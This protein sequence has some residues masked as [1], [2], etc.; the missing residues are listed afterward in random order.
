MSQTPPPK[1]TFNRSSPLFRHRQLSP[2]ASVR[3]SPLCL[4]AMTFGTQQSSRYGDCSRSTAFAILDHFYSSGGNF[5]D[6][7]NAYQFGQSEQWLGEWMSSRQNRDEMVV[8]TKY[9]TNYMARRDD[10]VQSNFSGNGAKSLKVSLEA[11]LA[12]LKTTYVDLL[13]VHWWDAATGIAEM[14][15][16]LNDVVVAGKVLYLGVSDTPAWVVSAAN[17]YARANGL[18]PFVVYQGMWSAALRDFER[19]IV[20]MAQQQGMGLC[21]YGVLNQGRFQTEEGFAE[22]LKTNP[23][24]KFIPTSERDR[25][26]SRV[27]EQIAKRKGVELLHVALAYVRQKEIGR[28]HV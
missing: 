23:G 14:M 15:H 26:V 4:G 18:R 22:R 1:I 17:E 16:A 19:D 8:A 25:R 2:S 3:V 9:T 12:N 27:L 6:T 11:S 24:R 20:P 5:L 13:Y 7:A 28:A 10:V 21:P